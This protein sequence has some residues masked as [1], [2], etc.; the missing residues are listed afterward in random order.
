[1]GAIDNVKEIVKI[2]GKLDNIDLYR[3]ILDLQSEV[4]ALTQANQELTGKVRELDE[5][6]LQV[7]KMTF[8]FPFYYAEGDDVPYCPRCWEGNKKAIHYPEPLIG[9]FGPIYTCL[10][11]KSRI[12]HPR[13]HR[14]ENGSQSYR[15]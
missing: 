1:M 15:L 14:Q 7:D 5:K 8:R 10:E 11:C 4:M 13:A 12:V 3:K 6:L 2:V 9:E